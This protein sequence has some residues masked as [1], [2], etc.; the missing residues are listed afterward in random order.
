M[1]IRIVNADAPA[2]ELEAAP[3]T[4]LSQAIWLSGRVA[5]APLCA[6]LGRCGRCRVRFA[7]NPPSP[8]PAEEEMLSPE[9]LELG[10]RLA[11][12]RQISDGDAAF[13]DL[14]LPRTTQPDWADS[15]GTEAAPR[16]AEESAGIM[17]LLLA[18]DVGTTSV[19]WLALAAAG[20]DRGS[21][22]ARGTFLNPQAGAGADVVSRLAFAART[23]GRR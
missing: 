22:I 23:E 3:G 18:V 21:A 6:G 10:W 2:L 11:C 7:R 14:E 17:P 8:L 13:W 5:P 9:E 4:P 12:R 1:K 15:G 19:Q 16:P 20:K